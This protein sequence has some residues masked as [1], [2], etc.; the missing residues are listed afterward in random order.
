[1]C[2]GGLKGLVIVD[3]CEL[4]RLIASCAASFSALE[5]RAASDRRDSLAPPTLLEKKRKN[6]EDP[7]ARVCARARGTISTARRWC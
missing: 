7:P 2:V 6:K 4:A 5:W 3:L 1:M